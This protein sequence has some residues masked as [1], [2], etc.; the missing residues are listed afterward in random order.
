MKN[1]KHT[2]GNRTRNIQVCNAVPQST[3]Q[4]AACPVLP[5]TLT[6]IQMTIKFHGFCRTKVKVHNICLRIILILLWT[7]RL[8]ILNGLLPLGIRVKGCLTLYV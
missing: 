1:Y 5:D 3:A 4:P 6:V 8:N 2:I 7:L